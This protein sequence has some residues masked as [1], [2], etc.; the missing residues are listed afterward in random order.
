MTNF[1]QNGLV[2]HRGPDGQATANVPHSWVMHSPDGFEWG[3][4]GSGP[5][6]LALNALLMVT[7]RKNAERL[8]QY[9]KSD[10]IATIP[11][12]GGTVSYQVIKEWVASH[13]E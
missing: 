8:H 12:E 1:E 7:D 3:Y 9:F 6:D 2:C 4:G 11:S 13:V 5:A 10:L